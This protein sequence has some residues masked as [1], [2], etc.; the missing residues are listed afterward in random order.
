MQGRFALP[1]IILKRKNMTLE[2]FKQFPNIHPL[3]VHFPIVFLLTAIFTQIA[4][5]LAPS[6]TGIKWVTFILLL[7]GCA[8]AQLAIQTSVHISGEA[9][10]KAFAIFETHRLFG[11]ATFWVSLIATV[12]RF[13]ANKWL[14]GKVVEYLLT[15]TIV[16]TGALVAIAGHQGAQMV[17]VYDVG[18][19]GN[20]VMSK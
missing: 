4:S 18:P 12:F 15:A 9:D 17:Y 19:K 5:L 20:G 11:L 14:K 10:D 16:I 1:C 2:L 8:G 3:V 13:V 7:A 6:K